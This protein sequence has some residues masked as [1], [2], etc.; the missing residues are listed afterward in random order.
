MN[1]T[2]KNIEEALQPLRA[3]GMSF[4]QL[5][6]D[7]QGVCKFSCRITDKQ[8]PRLG[9]NYEA[10]DKDP[11]AAIQAVAAQAERGK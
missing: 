5:T 7:D 8:N 11:V 6:W 1:M 10:K 4:A 2:G 9:K 3:R